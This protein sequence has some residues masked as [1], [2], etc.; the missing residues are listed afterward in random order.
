MVQGFG[1]RAQFKVEDFGASPH[2]ERAHIEKY[3][4]VFVDEDILARPEDFGG[5]G[6]PNTGKYAPWTSLESR[7][8]FQADLKR[9]IET[10]L[11]G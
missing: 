11:A 7:K 8:K 2:A 1:E 6:G 4:A 9:M 3:P 10:R 5:W